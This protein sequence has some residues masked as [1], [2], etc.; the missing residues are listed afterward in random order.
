MKPKIVNSCEI[1]ERGITFCRRVE[2]NPNN[3]EIELAGISF[4]LTAECH[5]HIE[6]EWE[7][8]E[9]ELN[10]LQSM[11]DKSVKSCKATPSDY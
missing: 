9:G 1:D 5:P 4:Q 11:V 10:K 7:N 8:Y 3:T 6:E 2:I